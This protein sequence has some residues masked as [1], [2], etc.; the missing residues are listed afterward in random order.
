MNLA[1]MAT[2]PMLSSDRKSQNSLLLLFSLSGRKWLPDHF[3][4]LLM[5]AIKGKFKFG[6]NP[7]KISCKLLFQMEL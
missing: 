1:T 6:S 5:P 3:T 7:G 4:I 2:K